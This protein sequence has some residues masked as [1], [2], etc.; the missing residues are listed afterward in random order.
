MDFSLWSKAEVLY[1]SASRRGELKSLTTSS[2]KVQEGE[3]QFQLRQLSSLKEKAKANSATSN[4]D[5][6]LPHEPSLYVGPVGDNHKLLLN[7]FN[8]LEQHLLLVTNHFEQQN[9]LLS[10]DDFSALY[11]C[12]TQ[13]PAL[14]FYNSSAEAGASQAHKHLQLI[15][16][17]KNAADL[18]PFS[19]QLE[20]LHD[21]V[22]RKLD[23]LPFE[24]AALALP[25]DLFNGDTPEDSVT[26][27][28]HLYD[29]LR[30][31]LSLESSGDKTVPP[32]NLLLT[33]E[34]MMVVPRKQEAFEGISLNALAFVGSILVKD[35]AHAKLIT[36][37][38][39]CK[40]LSEVSGLLK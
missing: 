37:Q 26:Q 22:P 27:L 34:W 38:G 30:T 23:S 14:A 39:L 7:K 40:A 20:H 5:P 36:Q 15:Q 6:F 4:N 24:H 2:H 35:K 18:I 33:H 8:V 32:H 28:Q 29:R 9:I 16:L 25:N 21:E 12:L 11:Q 10:L 1:T 19:P 13:G 3:L 31:T 17:D